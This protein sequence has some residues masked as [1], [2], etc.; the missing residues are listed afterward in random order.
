MR[1][2]IGGGTG[3]VESLDGVW[4][5]EVA[6]REYTHYLQSHIPALYVP[7]DMRATLMQRRKLRQAPKA[8]LVDMMIIKRIAWSERDPLA[9]VAVDE[10]GRARHR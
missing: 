3:E 6:A 4:G 5:G 9:P 8:S 10:A 2:Q 1:H 7:D